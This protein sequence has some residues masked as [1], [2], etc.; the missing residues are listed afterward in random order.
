MLEMLKCTSGFSNAKQFA[1]GGDHGCYR[2]AHGQNTNN[3]E[4]L[5][6]YLLNESI[7]KRE[8]Q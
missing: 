4:N 2:P 5:S 7:I 1:A 8:K 6:R 3:D